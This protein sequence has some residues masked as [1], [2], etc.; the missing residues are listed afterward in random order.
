MWW[1]TPCPWED[2][3]CLVKSRKHYRYYYTAMRFRNDYYIIYFWRANTKSQQYSEPFASVHV[4]AFSRANNG[5]VLLPWL[6]FVHRCR[7]LPSVSGYLLKPRLKVTTNIV[8]DT[9]VRLITCLAYYTHYVVVSICW[10]CCCYVYP[11]TCSTTID[12]S[13]DFTFCTAEPCKKWNV[14]LIGWLQCNSANLHSWYITL[15]YIL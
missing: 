8:M 5:D 15:Q 4:E 14:H 1:C 7:L 10:Q 13:D 12:Q 11:A 6:Y 2:W 3:I 9:L